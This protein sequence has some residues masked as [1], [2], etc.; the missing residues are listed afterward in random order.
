MP[1]SAGESWRILSSFLWKSQFQP[2][3]LWG[4]S[5]WMPFPVWG[6]SGPHVS[7]R[8]WF[9]SAS[10]LS[11]VS[12]VLISQR[13]VPSVSFHCERKIDMWTCVED[14]STSWWYHPS[15]DS[16]K[17]KLHKLTPFSCLPFWNCPQ[18]ILLFSIVKHVVGMSVTR[19]L[20][21]TPGQ[22][23]QSHLTQR[24]QFGLENS[25]KVT[26]LEMNVCQA[27][28]YLLVLYLCS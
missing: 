7:S 26:S 12:C 23:Q 14:Y 15:F 4:G 1:R 13:C 20:V 6:T 25:L 9:M 10:Q 2:W 8:G 18:Y 19:E 17:F 24:Y 21:F 22:V 3:C 11:K 27:R 16:L 28:L 5:S